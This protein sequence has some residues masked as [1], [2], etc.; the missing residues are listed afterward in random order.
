MSSPT[1][2]PVLSAAVAEFLPASDGS[3]LLDLTV[4]L[5]GHTHQYLASSSTSRAVG[6]DADPAALAVASERLSAF[7]DRVTL[8]NGNFANLTALLE[9]AG[10]TAPFSHILLDLGIGSH[11]LAS[12]DRGFSFQSDAPLIMAYGDQTGLPPAQLDALNVLQQRLGHVP[13]SHEIIHFLSVDDLAAVIRH[14]GEERYAGRIA[15][16]LK[17]HAAP[18]ITARQLADLIS[19]SVP[20]AYRHGRIHPATR[21]FQALRLA[22]NRELEALSVVLPQAVARLASG[23]RLA[24]ISFHSLEDRIV[25]HFFR[26]QAR[27]CICPHTQPICTC[28]HQQN[29]AIITNK[30]IRPNEAE[31][32]Q[33]PRSRSAKLRVAQKTP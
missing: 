22:V 15:R 17:E 7:N 8:L 11:Q 4:G 19:A 6:I 13:D 18:T 24:V 25:K 3:T 32:K 28:S 31:I 27:N 20:P 26:Q 12:A 29:L 9:S 1:H 10:L 5:G 23:G 21:T 30:P 16:R 2:I 33:N 14:Y